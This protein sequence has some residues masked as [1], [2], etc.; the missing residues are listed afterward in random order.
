MANVVFRQ[1]TQDGV[2]KWTTGSTDGGA[3]RIVME[4]C[5]EFH[6]VV[7]SAEGQMWTYGVGFHGCLVVKN[8]QGRLVLVAGSR[9]V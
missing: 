8:K 3:E 1:D 2:Y 6:N 7:V 4:T 9:G 5:R